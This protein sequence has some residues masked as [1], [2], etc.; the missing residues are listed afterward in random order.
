MDA[1]WVLLSGQFRTPE[2]T[3]SKVEIV[4]YALEQPIAFVRASGRIE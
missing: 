2:W 3:L 1:A 4:A